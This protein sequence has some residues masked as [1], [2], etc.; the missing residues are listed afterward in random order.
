[1]G[2]TAAEYDALPARPPREA[3]ATGRTSIPVDK[4]TKDA[5]D[6]LRNEG[7]TYDELLAR[8]MRRVSGPRVRP[9]RES[10]PTVQA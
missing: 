6:E 2:L 1:M 9:A 4:A 5:L 10:L 3:K 8:L 7:E